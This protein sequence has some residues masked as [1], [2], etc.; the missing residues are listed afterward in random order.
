V[1][2]ELRQ[3]FHTLVTSTVIPDNHPEPEGEE[4]NIKNKTGLGAFL[5]AVLSV[6]ASAQEPDD[7]VLEEI[8]V[9][10]TRLAQSGYDTPTPVTVVGI[11][12]IEADA[13][14]NIAD[15]VNQLPSVV[16]SSTPNTS[17]LSVS[18][19]GAGYNGINLR[20]L[21][22]TRTLTLL[23]GRRLPGAA[24][25]NAVDINT[26][27]QGLIERVEVVTGGASAVYG[28][29][30]LAGVV[31]FIL[32]DDYVGIKTD[33][34]GGTTTYGDDDNIKAVLTFGSEL[35]D[36]RGHI[37]FSAETANKNG[38][39]GVPRTWNNGGNF[40]MFN[41]DYT[42]TNGEPEILRM[43]QLGLTTAL[44]GGI[45][46]DT[47]LRGTAFGPGGTPYQFQ[48]GPLVRDPWMQGGDWRDAQANDKVTLTPKQTRD[49]VYTKITYEFTDT[50]KGDFEYSNTNSRNEG[51]CCS[52]FNVGNI[53]ILADNAFIPETVAT[54]VAALGITQ[55]TLGSM[56][57]DLFP[58]TSRYRRGTERFSVGLNGAFDMFG[59]NWTFEVYGQRGVTEVTQD[60]R[61]TNRSHFAMA[62]DSVLDP[63]TGQIVCRSTLTDPNNGCKPYNP[64]GVGVNSEA[65]I[66]YLY[67]GDP[68]DADII[69]P[70]R[71]EELTQ[72]VYAISFAGSPFSMPAGDVGIAFGIEHRS[73]EIS[74]VADS[75]SEINGW[76]NGNFKPVFG[77]Y[78]VN[79]AF[80]EVGVPIIEDR[81]ELNAAVR[82]TDY[83]TS[84]SVTTWKVGTTFSPIGDLRL[85]ATVSRDI[86]APNLGELFQGSGAQTNSVSDP[87]NNNATVQFLGIISGNP[88]LTPEEADTFA[89]GFIYE[90]S[91]IEG[92]RMSV[93]YYDIEISDA[94][95]SVGVQNIV[96]R[97]FEGNQTFCDAIT[98]GI[99]PTGILE[100]QEVRR[101]PFNFV[102][103]DAEG[104]DFAANYR[105]DGLGGDWSF[106]AIATHYL[107]DES[108]NGVNVVFNNVGAI[109]G[110]N[111]PDW[112]TR[113]SATY[114]RDALTTTLTAR[115]ISDGVHNNSNILCTSGCPT[116]TSI[117]RT[118]SSNRIAGVMTFDW[119]AAYNVEIQNADAQFYFTIRNLLNKE[120]PR[121]WRGPGGV[122]HQQIATNPNLY[123]LL[124][125]VFRVGLRVEF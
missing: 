50:L 45:I 122:S 15:I 35:F 27:P 30:A 76:F 29:D 70:N 20:S 19:G 40:A 115:G 117:N 48:Y 7:A 59:S 31:N 101:S 124:G 114:S 75:V 33:I 12:Q 121:I 102:T 49:S 71:F 108:D 89:V 80:L 107:T 69:G 17:N 53:N 119:S 54:Q 66:D 92:L 109:T 9:S 123:D 88:N 104:V 44:G 84:G 2:S 91:F 95:G 86:R 41:P 32:N 98:R 65:T 37:V 118:V 62:L 57:G 79:E 46:T 116:S 4:M 51:W 99:G 81:L 103:V 120:P 77:K 68:P 6:G 72:N 112:I 36:G 25:D 60:A 52:Q 34:S 93:D 96:D 87:F 16:G 1:R 13:P 78:D 5:A 73:E 10:G 85:R 100:I 113:M 11:A 3:Q 39:F 111:P 24:N 38:I 63:V 42:P 97:C 21:G 58:I 56:N 106:D 23:N 47:A 14:H 43:P 61:T 110:G 83:S 55:F 94:I 74:G 26:I 28:S 90:P 8:I 105:T 67:R 64:M 82:A 18:S 125:T 22:R